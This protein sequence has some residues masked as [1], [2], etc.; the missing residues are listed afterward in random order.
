MEPVIRLLSEKE[1]AVDHIIVGPVLY[2]RATSPAVVGEEVSRAFTFTPE[3]PRVGRS[4]KIKI[5]P[6]EP[7]CMLRPLEN[8]PPYYSMPRSPEIL[9][10]LDMGDDRRIQDIQK[11]AVGSQDDVRMRFTKQLDPSRR[12]VEAT[13]CVIRQLTQSPLGGGAT[14]SLPP[15]YGK[16]ACALYVTTRLASRVLILVHTTV[17]LRQW[18]E[19]I[20]GFVDGV[21][22]VMA[23]TPQTYGRGP[24]DWP[25]GPGVYV[26]VL[27]QT[28]LARYSPQHQSLCGSFDMVIV[29]ETHHLAARTLCKVM[30]VAGCRYRLGLSGTLERKDGMH[31]LLDHLLGGA[32]FRVQR[33]HDTRLVVETVQYSAGERYAAA[34]DMGF[35]DAVSAT[36]EDPERNAL[37]LDVILSKAREGRCVIVMSGRRSQLKHLGDRLAEDHGIVP[38]WGVGGSRLNAENV[39]D[40]TVLLAT[41]EYAAEGLDV[42]RLD[43]CILATSKVDVRQCVGRILRNAPSSSEARRPIVVDIHDTDVPILHRQHLSRRRFFTRP[44]DKEGMGATVSPITVSWKKNN[45][46]SSS[47]SRAA[48]ASR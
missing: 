6:P 29:D 31:S 41:Y 42:P 21:S 9:Q 26:I 45:H 34:A 2:F 43:T 14:L 35:V 17:L 23:V 4:V 12:Q 20:S 37:L 46:P 11:P 30:E 39:G 22:A 10:V 25:R 13:D 33:E 32:A 8:S 47:P 7:V 5:R 28:V 40:G 1:G 44:L 24:E 38:E 27:I 18:V 48:A 36:S 3:A 19:R 15:G 16:T